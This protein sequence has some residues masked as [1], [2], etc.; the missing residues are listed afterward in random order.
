MYSTDKRQTGTARKHNKAKRRSKYLTKLVNISR[1]NTPI[2]QI[3]PVQYGYKSTGAS[4]SGKVTGNISNLFGS[5]K[6]FIKS[7]TLDS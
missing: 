2:K 3:N 5:F 6:N 1:N 7:K 4:I